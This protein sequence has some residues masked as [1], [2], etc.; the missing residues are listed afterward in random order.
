[1]NYPILFQ[2]GSK[3]QDQITWLTAL[4]AVQ[5]GL[6]AEKMGGGSWV[7]QAPASIFHYL[8]PSFRSSKDVQG[9]YSFFIMWRTL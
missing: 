4:V 9:A 5:L 6:W 2:V 8:P 7:V 1:M 3:Y